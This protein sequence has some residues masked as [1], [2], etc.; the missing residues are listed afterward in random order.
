MTPV[1]LLQTD[2]QCYGVDRQ[3]NASTFTHV[4]ANG[5]HDTFQYHLIVAIS[6]LTPPLCY[7]CPRLLHDYC[8]TSVEQI[9][10]E[11]LRKIEENENES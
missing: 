4:L 11:R 5:S 6:T 8:Y 9:A 3:T 1:A 10:S 7:H 2:H